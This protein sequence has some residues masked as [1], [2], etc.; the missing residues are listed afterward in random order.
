[1]THQKIHA[2]ALTRIAGAA[3]KARLDALIAK[4]YDG[5][6]NTAHDGKFEITFIMESDAFGKVLDD[7]WTA[8]EETGL[9]FPGINPSFDAEKCSYTFDWYRSSRR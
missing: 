2:S 7:E 6:L 8:M 5:I 3:R 1:M 9:L 4:Y